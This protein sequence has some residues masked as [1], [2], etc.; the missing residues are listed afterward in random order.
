MTSSAYYYLRQDILAARVDI[1]AVPWIFQIWNSIGN[2]VEGKHPF[3][4]QAC[5]MLPCSIQYFANAYM[6]TSF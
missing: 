2:S 6:V 1:A 4:R 3:P 5:L